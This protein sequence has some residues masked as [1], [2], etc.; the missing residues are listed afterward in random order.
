M[1]WVWK[2]VIVRRYV[3]R[4]VVIGTTMIRFYESL[5]TMGGGG[6]GWA[7]FYQ[8]LVP[9]GGSCFGKAIFIFGGQGVPL[10]ASIAMSDAEEGTIGTLLMVCFPPVPS[11]SLLALETIVVMAG[12]G[13]FGRGHGRM[14]NQG[15]GGER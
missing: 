2:Y 6:F 10:H 1:T 12:V 7:R 5:V 3:E 4:R 15:R 13:V 8:V 14:S 9:V 11:E